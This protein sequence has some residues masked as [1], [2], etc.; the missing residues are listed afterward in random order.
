MVAVFLFGLIMSTTLFGFS[1]TRASATQ[2]KL[3]DIAPIAIVVL[4]LLTIRLY[5]NA[6]LQNLTWNHTGS[7][8]FQFRSALR[9]RSLL[10][11]TIKNWLLIVL[12]LGM[13]WPFA[14]IAT[15]RMRLQAV[16]LTTQ[17]SPDTLVNHARTAQGE[18]AGDAAADL[19]GLD[20][21]L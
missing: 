2:L 21:G 13:Y 17:D 6:R 1:V 7:S 18:A 20:V 11:L 8:V 15:A 10:G 5:F 3:V 16:S 19:F 14:A 9:F 12:T 4:T